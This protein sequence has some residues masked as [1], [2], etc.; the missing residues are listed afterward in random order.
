MQKAHRNAKAH[1]LARLTLGCLLAA[2]FPTSL[3]AITWQDEVGEQAYIDLGT[4]FNSV[5]QI[6][7]E[8]TC[9]WRTT[10]TA[11][12]FGTGVLIAPDIVLTSAHVLS[13]ASSVGFDI[14]GV[15]YSATEWTIYAP[16]KR[17]FGY[18]ADAA[19]V[20]LS[21]PVAGIDPAVRYTGNS[22]EGM[23]AVMV[24]FGYG[25]TGSTGYDKTTDMILRGATNVIDKVSWSATRI[26]T[27]F[28]S[29]EAS[30][31]KWIGHLLGNDD[32][33][34]LEGALAPGD[35]GG[36]LF[37]DVEGE[38]QLAGIGS[39]GRASPWHRWRHYMRGCGEDNL[40]KWTGA[41]SA[42]GAK[43][44]F[45]SVPELNEWID[46]M[47]ALESFDNAEEDGWDRWCRGRCHGRW[48]GRFG[49]WGREYFSAGI[50]AEEAG[51]NEAELTTETDH[52]FAAVMSSQSIAIVG[53][54][55]DSEPGS[56]VVAAG[57]NETESE[58]TAYS[59]TSF[60]AEP[61]LRGAGF[62]ST[63]AISES[64]LFTQGGASAVPEPGSLMLL[65]VGLLVGG[66]ARSSRRR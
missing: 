26:Y 13:G 28:D 57:A 65:L 46:E 21:E 50:S 39:Y 55:V 31:C 49:P 6:A 58:P 40:R 19:L 10:T 59:D 63:A 41:A 7:V 8:K 5:G 9:G 11:N 18:P 60:S 15:A 27:D 33:T 35:S 16:D 56:L 22:L 20:R 43:S 38:Y 52:A 3:F 64:V 24:G 2:L 23:E 45:T 25:G 53:E 48:Y 47:L 17:R 14:D 54:E 1:M 42:Y 61:V 51:D 66:L 36:G 37:I 29:P 30:K 32:P 34:S 62:L 12:V 4:Q 44:V